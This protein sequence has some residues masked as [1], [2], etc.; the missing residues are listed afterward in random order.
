MGGGGAKKTPQRVKTTGWGRRD[1]VGR[2]TG[3]VGPKKPPNESLRLVGWCRE[4]VGDEKGT[5]RV[6]M[7][8][9]VWWWDGV[10]GWWGQKNPPTSRYDS[11]GA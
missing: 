3:V 6:V 9:W 1:V 10:P 4:V 7:T 11:L 8:R 5:Q 2:G